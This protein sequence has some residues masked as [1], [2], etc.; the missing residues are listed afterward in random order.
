MKAIVFKRYGEPEVLQIEEIKKPVPKNNEV[1]IRIF[2][3]SVTAEDPKM[4][5]FNHPPLLKLPVGLM[6]GFKKPKNPV[7]GIEFSGTIEAIGKEVK[8]YK[9]GDEV[10]GYTGLSFGAYAEY[11]CMPENGLIH[12]IPENLSF[13]ESACMVN[14]PLSALAYMKKKGNIKQGDKILIYGASGSVGTAAVQLAKYFGA[15]VTGVCSTKNIEL[16]SSIGADIVIDYTCQDFTQTEEKYDL[17]FDTVGKTSMKECLK[18]LRPKGRYLLTEFGFSHIL[19]S[20][21]TSL[22]KSKKVIVAS[23]NFYWKIE[24]LELFREIAEKG[25]FKPVIDKTFPLER[26]I[27]A[28]KYVELGHKAGNV[29]ISIK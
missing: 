20:I 29:A 8:K 21:F 9:I 3:T 2:A 4:R 24:D 18:L 19:A 27:E 16:V 10:F 7:L 11:K 13:E 23:S 14:G 1:L 6:F 22:F 26:I 5:G 12:Y 28:H 15:H 25:Y 17:L